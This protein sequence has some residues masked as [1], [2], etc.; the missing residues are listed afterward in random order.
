MYLYDRVADTAYMSGL[1][2][3]TKESGKSYSK[4]I[5]DIRQDLLS[6]ITPDFSKR[7]EYRK[8]EKINKKEQATTNYIKLLATQKYGSMSELFNGIA[9]LNAAL[10]ENK[11]KNTTH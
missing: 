5:E 1:N 3:L 2:V 10:E 9:G 11:W 8:R 6:L 4:Q 7:K